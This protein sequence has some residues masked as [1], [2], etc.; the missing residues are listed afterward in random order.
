MTWARDQECCVGHGMGPALGCTAQRT[1]WQVPLTHDPETHWPSEMHDPF[2]GTGSH[3]SVVA[4]H[5]P[6]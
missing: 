5:T 4:L 6:L 1:F 3:T 2:S